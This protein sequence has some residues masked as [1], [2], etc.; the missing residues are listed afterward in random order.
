MFSE[1]IIPK[2]NFKNILICKVQSMVVSVY[3]FIFCCPP[4][5]T[6]LLTSFQTKLD[7]CQSPTQTPARQICYFWGKK[8]LCNHV[9]NWNL[10]RGKFVQP[11]SFGREFHKNR[12]MD[13]AE[14]VL[15]SVN[16]YFR[17]GDNILNQIY[18]KQISMS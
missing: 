5:T 2:K 17:K 1:T 16:M 11:P 4:P 12:S 15:D 8:Q 3:W 13:D 7:F 10:S 6:L 18:E 14:V 9:R